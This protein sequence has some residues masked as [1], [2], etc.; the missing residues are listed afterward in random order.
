MLRPQ[1]TIPPNQVVMT[2]VEPR[3]MDVRATVSEDDLGDLRP[4]LPGTAVPT[5]YPELRLPVDLD[6]V[7]DIPIGPG[8]FDGRLNVHLKGK[9]KLLMPGMTC[10]IKLVP[11]RKTEAILVPPKVI[12]TDEL[13][14][15]KQYVE[16]LGKDGKPVRRNVTVG[17]KTD[18]QVEILAG[19][20]AGEKVVLEPKKD[21][22]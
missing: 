14:D 18:K 12:V 16:V 8:R 4:G 1:G 7:S 10:K 5:G 13:D 17:R 6:S 15:E 19:L 9:S 21:A 3:P 22:D 20:K 11:Y 2:I